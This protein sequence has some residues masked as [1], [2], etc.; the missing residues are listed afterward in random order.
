MGKV[1]SALRASLST[2]MA[3][4]FE[5]ENRTEKVQEKILIRLA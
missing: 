5:I 3:L 2:L 4:R 1:L